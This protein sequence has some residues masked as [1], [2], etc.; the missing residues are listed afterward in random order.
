M[1]WLK[2]PGDRI[3]VGEP[4]LEVSTDKISY[5]VESPVGGTLAEALGNEGDEFAPGAVIGLVTDEGERPTFEAH[6]VP[7]PALE[8]G[9]ESVEA[10]E[11][12]QAAEGRAEPERTPA[13]PAARRLAREMGVELAGIEG[14]GPRGRITLDDVAAAP[15]V[16]AHSP[17]E[18]AAQLAPEQPA[19]SEQPVPTATE[20]LPPHL[21]AARRTIFRKYERNRPYPAGAGRDDGAR[22]RAAR[23][24]QRRGDVGWTAFVAFAAA[25]LLRDYPVLRTDSRSG[26]PHPS[27]TSASRPTRRTAW[28]FR[29]SGGRDAQPARHPGR[30][31]APRG[32]RAGR[33]PRVGRYR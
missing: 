16:E 9:A 23:L 1:R 12:A 13:S 22:R 28:W 2:A 11:S 24:I 4:L 20:A 32:R 15:A 31:R 26:A 8:L 25:R 27:S 29:S 17:A 3:A 33:T 21:A 18:P 19:V 7:V 30:D 10:A 6:A 5:E 14:S